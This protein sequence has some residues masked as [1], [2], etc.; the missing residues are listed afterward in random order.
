MIPI[1]DTI[2]LYLDR[3]GATLWGRAFNINDKEGR[4]EAIAFIR[5]LWRDLEN[6]EVYILENAEIEYLREVAGVKDATS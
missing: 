1:D 3:L 6:Y 4:D 2:N 5:D